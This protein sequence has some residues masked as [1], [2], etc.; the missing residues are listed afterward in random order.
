MVNY[1]ERGI[2][3]P[4]KLFP[5]GIAIYTSA[6]DAAFSLN[7][8]AFGLLRARGIVASSASAMQGQCRAKP[9]AAVLEHADWPLLRTLLSVSLGS[10]W[11]S[12]SG[13]IRL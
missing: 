3:Q 1:R 4:S 7:R 13:Q 5:R 8:T 11:H 6:R 9:I 12:P 10:S 2:S